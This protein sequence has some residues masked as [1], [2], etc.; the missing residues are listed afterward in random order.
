MRYEY[1]NGEYN[2]NSYVIDLENNGTSEIVKIANA[3]FLTYVSRKP[4]SKDCNSDKNKR[5]NK[6]TRR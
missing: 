3:K 4:R 1:I 6:R 5:T 2:N